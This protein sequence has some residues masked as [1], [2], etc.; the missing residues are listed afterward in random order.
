MAPALLLVLDEGSEPLVQHAPGDAIETLVRGRGQQ[1]VREADTFAVELENL[2]RESRPEHLLGAFGASE[3]ADGG[4]SQCGDHRQGLRRR[5]R[6]RLETDEREVTQTLG[7][8]RQLARS[9]LGSHSEL[10]RVEG[11]ASRDVVHAAQ[12]RSRQDHS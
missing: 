7:H 9:R 10:E 12:R 3:E 1:R 6:Q 4:A 5:R 2:R 11:I 8:R